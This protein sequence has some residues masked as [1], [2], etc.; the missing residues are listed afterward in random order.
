MST[1]DD[2]KFMGCTIN[3]SPTVRFHKADDLNWIL[4]RSRVIPL[5]NKAGKENKNGGET[6]WE[7]QSYH[8]TLG[9]ACKSAAHNLAD[10]DTD[11]T[12]LEE[13]AQRLTRIGRDIEE[14][15]NEAVAKVK[16]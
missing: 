2:K 14:A 8:A 15:V 16:P 13:Y 1:K 6:V 7:N 5:T 4:Q 12:T 3:I 11:I 10:S 9:Q